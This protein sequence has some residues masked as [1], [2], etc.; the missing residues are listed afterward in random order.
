MSDDSSGGSSDETSDE[1]SSS[2]ESSEYTSEGSPSP[3][4]RGS[5]PRYE[6]SSLASE[7]ILNQI[8]LVIP[9][10]KV[11][12][13]HMSKEIKELTAEKESYMKKYQEQKRI[14][15]SLNA[16]IHD[17]QSLVTES[18]LVKELRAELAG[19][20]QSHRRDRAR[21]DQHLEEVGREIL[22]YR[23]QL[24]TDMESKQRTTR[25]EV[26]KLKELFEQMDSQLQ[27]T[28]RELQHK[29][30]A[31][32]AKKVAHY[33]DMEAYRNHVRSSYQELLKE[34]RLNQHGGKISGLGRVLEAFN[35]QIDCSQK[36]EFDSYAKD[37][38]Y[39]NCRSPWCS[40][41]EINRLRFTRRQLVNLD[42][43]TNGAGRDSTG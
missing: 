2:D 12:F 24:V 6:P 11:V 33:R 42:R 8:E 40:S 28:N 5:L 22:K 27:E 39:C 18:F 16:Q 36:P 21:F 23:Q 26:L 10:M 30:V 32:H 13:D 4:L 37:L 1:S 25:E 31:M 38:P 20:T 17:N 15:N 43:P 29:K 19:R 9:P 14:A 41:R 34:L 7:D 35:S 3:L